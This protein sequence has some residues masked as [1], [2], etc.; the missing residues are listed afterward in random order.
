MFPAHPLVV[1][2]QEVHALT[3]F[4]KVHDPRLGGLEL[5]TKLGQDRRQRSECAFGL[6]PRSAHGQQ[7]IRVADQH[8]RATVCPL[9]VE[10][11]QVDVGQA[12]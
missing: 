4:P 9:P 12:G 7:I 2:A 11:V 6:L 1:K 8:A 10:P 5:K 3:T